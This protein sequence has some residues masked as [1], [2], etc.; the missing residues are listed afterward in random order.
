MSTSINLLYNQNKDTYKIFLKPNTKSSGDLHVRNVFKMLVANKKHHDLFGK[1][2]SLTNNPENY[3]SHTITS[4]Q[5]LF[6]IICGKYEN[7]TFTYCYKF[8]G[9]LYLCKING[10]EDDEKCKHK[11]ICNKITGI[12]CAGV[13][14]FSIGECTIYIDNMSGTYKPQYSN[15]EIFKKDFENSFP[16]INIKLLQPLIDDPSRDDR[17]TYCDVMKASPD[18]DMVCKSATSTNSGGRNKKTNKKTKNRRKTRR[19][20][21]KKIYKKSRKTKTKTK[22]TKNTKNTK[23]KNNRVKHNKKT[24]KARK[25][26]NAR[27]TRKH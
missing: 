20:I 7:A 5:E 17:S 4:N 23:K 16:N 12:V 10:I 3:I 25:S 21:T 22:N 11:W 6:D 13:M 14:Q 18:Y 26:R 15:L 2:V 9:R 1:N 27:K 19:K 24:K 8:D